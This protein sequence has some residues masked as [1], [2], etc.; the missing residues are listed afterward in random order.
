[1][2]QAIGLH[3][4]LTRE[5]EPIETA[6]HKDDTQQT[7]QYQTNHNSFVSAISPKFGGYLTPEAK[8]R[9][10]DTHEGMY[11]EWFTRLHGSASLTTDP[12]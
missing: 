3:Y 2:R 6:R 5:S 12:N 7:K 9:A 10:R 1:M 8:T 11:L 4:L